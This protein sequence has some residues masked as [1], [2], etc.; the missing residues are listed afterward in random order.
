[1]AVSKY[2]IITVNGP[3]PV[4][5]RSNFVV[6]RVFFNR[7]TAALG[8]ELNDADLDLC[9]M[10]KIRQ[11]PRASR[12][13]CVVDSVDTIARELHM[14]TC[15]TVVLDVSVVDRN[16]PALQ[17]LSRRL[18]P[19]IR[20]ACCVGPQS[21]P[22][23]SMDAVVARMV[24]DLCSGMVAGSSSS[25]S[26]TCSAAPGAMYVYLPHTDQLSAEDVVC[27]TACALAQRQVPGPPLVVELQPWSRMHRQVLAT[28]QTVGAEV[29]C[30]IFSGSVLS[31]ASIEYFSAL[32]SETIIP[33]RVAQF[34]I[35]VDRLGAT[36]CPLEGPMYP[37]D[38]EVCHAVLRLIE[39]GFANRIII[40]PSIR[41]RMDL[42]SFGGPGFSHVE[43]LFRVRLSRDSDSRTERLLGANGIEKIAW[44]IPP[45]LAPVVLEK[46][47]C[48]ICSAFFIP[49]D[50]YEKFSFVYCS[51]KCL[52]LHR[53]AGWK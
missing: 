2:N 28:L 19:E 1:M 10:W 32:L 52:N 6:S 14:L 47:K 7:T 5:N 8:Q 27:L 31:A 23:L 17:A 43:E 53:K 12:L 21:M 16:D 13:N 26:E 48:F 34:C 42:R 49:G 39:L 25:C 50:H 3:A 51:S 33:G 40:S 9:S 24:S 11:D 15:P 20:L 46:W 22:G 36:E 45:E 41:F 38:E 44:Y 37:T 35:C 4:D 29:D 30:L 18:R